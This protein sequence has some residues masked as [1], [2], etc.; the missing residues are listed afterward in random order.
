MKYSILVFFTFIFHITFG[1]LNTVDCDTVSVSVL[2]DSGKH[3]LSN[4]SK[5]VLQDIIRSLNE[6]NNS[7]IE[8]IGHTDARGSI[9][10]NQNLSKNR[11]ETVE[12]YLLDFMD[13]TV[14]TDFYGESKLLTNKGI[15]TSDSL[16]RRVEIRYFEN[17]INL[18]PDN[19]AGNIIYNHD[20]NCHIDSLSVERNYNNNLKG[21]K[22]SSI[23]VIDW[24]RSMYAYGFEL[25]KW[26]KKHE[27]EANFN[28]V[29][30]FNDGDGKRTSM[31]KNGKTGGIYSTRLDSISA[32]INLMENVAHKGTGGDYPENYI[33]ALIYAQNKYPTV[34]TLIL[35]ADN[36][37][38]IRDYKL[39]AQL[40]K[41]VVVILN[42]IDL[43]SNTINYQYINLVAQTGGR[44]V[45]MDS[46]LKTIQFKNNQG[47]KP[48]YFKDTLIVLPKYR[49]NLDHAY[50]QIT[51]MKSKLLKTSIPPMV[52]IDSVEF[53]RCI[54]KNIPT[55]NYKIG[56]AK[57]RQYDYKLKTHTQFRVKFT[58]RQKI[59]IKW[60]HR[61][62]VRYGVTKY[63]WRKIKCVK[64]KGI[65]SRDVK[66]ECLKEKKKCNQEKSTCKKNK[67]KAK[68]N[69]KK[70][71]V[72]RRRDRKRERKNR[73]KSSNDSEKSSVDESI[74]IEDEQ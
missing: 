29:V 12:N 1:Q 57:C 54:N 18:N 68:R 59:A 9:K 25:L 33:E 44:L 61:A 35:I 64:C 51:L 3:S 17:C 13:A 47:Y 40:N 46:E 53:K 56:C 6:S 41:P 42:E 38:C 60:R 28:S 2:F 39:M 55:T 7:Y 67:I 8:L 49:G 43:K 24:T 26:F 74:K 71:R 11:A 30:I 52:L 10:Y 19:K 63:K 36:R 20:S 27:L 66:K 15:Q 72:K 50:E 70:Y 31:K 65:K 23:V 21:V 32:V 5:S 69:L 45:F 4:V 62:R 58:F 48:I 73:K 37:A 14:K 22:G 16:N 34:D